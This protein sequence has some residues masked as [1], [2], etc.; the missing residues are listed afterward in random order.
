VVRGL[1]LGIV[2]LEFRARSPAM[3]VEAAS[4]A[5]DL[6]VKKP[7]MRLRTILSLGKLH[8]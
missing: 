5:S 6:S 2:T 3:L 4:K 8:I 7:S 1:D